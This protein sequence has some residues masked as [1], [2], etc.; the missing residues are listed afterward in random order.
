MSEKQTYSRC[1]LPYF[2]K[3]H[4]FSKLLHLW[5]ACFAFCQFTLMTG[6]G[7]RG[8]TGVRDYTK[9]YFLT[10]MNSHKVEKVMHVFSIPDLLKTL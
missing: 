8:E 6:G 3:N 4:T 1:P 10:I 5:F 7:C 9:W 2:K